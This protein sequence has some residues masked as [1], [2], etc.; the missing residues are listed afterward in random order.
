[1]AVNKHYCQGTFCHTNTTQDRFQKSSGTLRGRYAYAT[2]TDQRNANDNFL[3]FCSNGCMID[4]VNEHTQD[5]INNRPINFI[6][7]RRTSGGYEKHTETYSSGYKYN[8]IRK[9]NSQNS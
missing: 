4:W 5:I 8:T 1:M 6:T 2:F 7:E 3:I 9:I